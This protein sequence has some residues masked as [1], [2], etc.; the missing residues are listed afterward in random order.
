MVHCVCV[1][2]LIP[3]RGFYAQISS[4]ITSEFPGVTTGDVQEPAGGGE[5]LDADKEATPASFGRGG[6]DAG[7]E[8]SVAEPREVVATS[9]GA[10]ET[11][12]WRP[13]AEQWRQRHSCR[14]GRTSRG[15][16][17]K[18]RAGRGREGCCDAGEGGGTV[19][20]RVGEADVTEV[21]DED[22][23]VFG[24]DDTMDYRTIIV[25]RVLSTQIFFVINNRRARVIIDGGS[26]NNLVSSDLVK[27]LGLT[28]RTH[29]HPYH[30]QWLNDSG[31]AKAIQ[32]CRVSFSIGSYADFVDCDVVPM[33]ACSF[34]LGRPWEH[35]N[36]ATHH[37]RSNKYT[38]VHNGKKITLL[39][40]TLPEIV[41]ADKERA[42][43]LKL[44]ESENQQVAKS[45]FPPKKDKL[46][47][48]SKVEGIK[49]KGGVM[50]AT[51]CDI[52]DISNDDMRYFLIC[53][54]ALVSLDDIASSIPPV[55]TNL[56]QEYEDVFP[57]EIPPGL[58][59]MRGIEH[60]IDLIPGA[61]L[62]NRAAYRTNP[63]ETKE[64]QRQVQD[65]LDR[66]YGIE[67]DESKIEA[68]RSW[69]V[70]QTI[71]QVRSFLGLA[72]FYHRFVKDFSTF[73]APLN[74]LMKKGVVFHWG[75]TQEKSFDTLKD[76]LTHT[77]LLQLPNFGK[78]FELEC[79]AS[80][81]G[82]GGVLMQDGKPV[83]Y[84]SEKL[85]GPVLNYSTYDKELYA[86]IPSFPESPF[87][88]KK[89]LKS[90]K[91]SKAS[92]TD[93]KQPFEHVDPI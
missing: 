66:G 33:K 85:H 3:G 87:S 79:D 76:K 27:K 78:T 93:P 57:A 41:E 23:E 74:E 47:P 49:L 38:F 19:G 69:P 26:C 44:D 75:K 67:V 5:V 29:P 71:T 20:R 39:P 65:L 90:S 72:G 48:S 32:V 82:I 10:R 62:P 34:L 22:G 63:D 24:R 2:R 11:R 89:S 70:P 7:D 35:D 8:G 21:E 15:L 50:L 60:Q 25:Q 16:R 18:R 59:P 84:F 17:A 30:I 13:E 77:P 1:P 56:L 73:A 51:K 9:A 83:A 43:S 64:I 92:H 58:P 46:S 4:E 80:G 14:R 45:V 53:K 52:A 37:G 86:L 31:R 40:L 91:A 42:A 68:T 36:D 55:V 6:G 54:Q 12:Q 61:S 81:V 28:T 88:R